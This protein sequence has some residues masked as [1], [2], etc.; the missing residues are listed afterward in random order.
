VWTPTINNLG[1]EVAEAVAAKV[2]GTDSRSGGGLAVVGFDT[3]TKPKFSKGGDA[4]PIALVQIATLRTAVLFR[5][6]HH[7]MHPVLSALLSVSDNI[8]Q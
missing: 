1:R 6:S 7:G 5:A 2:W 4:N 3:E 8:L